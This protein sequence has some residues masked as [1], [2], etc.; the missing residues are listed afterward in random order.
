[1]KNLLFSSLIFVL[2]L[3]NCSE[4]K[5]IYDVKGTV[6]ELKVDL[7]KI[8]IAHDTIPNLMMPMEMDFNVKNN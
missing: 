2:L 6:Y 8:R 3:T 5:T 1:M 7:N 4:S